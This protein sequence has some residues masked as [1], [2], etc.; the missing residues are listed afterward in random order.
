M[1]WPDFL[2]KS[3]CQSWGSR[4]FFSVFFMEKGRLQVP[5][6]PCP[7]FSLKLESPK[8]ALLLFLQVTFSTQ[9]PNICSGNTS[10]ID[11]KISKK[12]EKR[13][14]TLIWV[15]YT[16]CPT[17]ELSSCLWYCLFLSTVF[18][19]PHTSSQIK[20]ERGS[21][22]LVIRPVKVLVLRYLRRFGKKFLASNLLFH[23]LIPPLFFPHIFFVVFSQRF[24]HNLS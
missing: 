2:R 8:V 3:G 24:I 17:W 11:Q 16:L 13:E 10:K 15:V 20:G 19:L 9:L 5:T 12:R 21:T 22:S 23:S 6:S 4:Y 1:R 7:F 14:K 18:F